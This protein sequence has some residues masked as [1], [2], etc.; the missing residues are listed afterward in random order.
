MQRL[1]DLWRG[2]LPLE[3]AF[4]KYAIIYGLALNVVATVV[5]LMLVALDA[6]I[7][8]A[9]IVHLLPVPYGV[10]A[11]CGVWRSA[12]RSARRDYSSLAKAGVV[13][14]YAFWLVA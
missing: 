14:W 6:P 13:A 4:W 3:T 5:A 8:Y 10:L 11:I 2:H 7:A 9:I 12:D 1:R